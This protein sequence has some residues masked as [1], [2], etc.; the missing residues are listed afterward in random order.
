M[1]N[2]KDPSPFE[3]LYLE[4]TNSV[5]AIKSSITH[6]D[7]DDCAYCAASRG[8]NAYWRTTPHEK[9]SYW[10]EHYARYGYEAALLKMLQVVTPDNPP[11]A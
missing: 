4:C 10:R 1:P 8:D 7:Y 6:P 9:W 11:D 5:K 3:V 2:Q